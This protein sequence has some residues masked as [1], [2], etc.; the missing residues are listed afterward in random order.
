VIS[1]SRRC[2]G[3]MWSAGNRV[4]SARGLALAAYD[5]SRTSAGRIFFPRSFSKK[6]LHPPRQYKC[7]ILHSEGSSTRRDDMRCTSASVVPHTTGG[8]PND[9]CFPQSNA[10][11]SGLTNAPRAAR[12]KQQQNYYTYFATVDSTGWSTPMSSFTL[13]TR[14]LMSSLTNRNGSLPTAPGNAE[15]FTASTLQQ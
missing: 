14:P 8:S 1:A 5:I 12:G 7:D 2:D 11:C 15:K 10:C 9:G 6:Y 3:A 4:A 13:P